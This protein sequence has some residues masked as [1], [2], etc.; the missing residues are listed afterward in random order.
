M[1][2]PSLCKEQH[3]LKVLLH[4]QWQMELYECSLK[5]PILT[6]IENKGGLSQ[7]KFAW[8][9]HMTLFTSR[10]VWTED[11][12]WEARVKN[13]QPGLPATSADLVQLNKLIWSGL[14]EDVWFYF[15]KPEARLSML[16]PD[17]MY[18]QII[19]YQISFPELSS[20]KGSIRT[21]F[22]GQ[23]YKPFHSVFQV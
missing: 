20:E 3:Q 6:K 4:P 1:D 9:T 13:A 18:G 14:K 23:S 5:S 21:H 12:S 16:A 17:R 8:R 7:Q 10:A 22:T 19:R 11:F 15:W 2:R